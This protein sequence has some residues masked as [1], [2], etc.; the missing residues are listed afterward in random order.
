[1]EAVLNLDEAEESMV[2]EAEGV[3]NAQEDEATE[4]EGRTRLALTESLSLYK[5][6]YRL[7]TILPLTFQGMYSAK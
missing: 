2:V 5:M 7:K 4:E 1:M 6:V 3:T